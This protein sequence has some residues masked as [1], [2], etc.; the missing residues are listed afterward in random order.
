MNI[1]DKITE[2]QQSVRDEFCIN[3]LE[4]AQIDKELELVLFVID[5]LTDTTTKCLKDGDDMHWKNMEF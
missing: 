1:K 5:A 3:E 2:W 4:R